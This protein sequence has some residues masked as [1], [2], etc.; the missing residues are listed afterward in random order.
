MKLEPI[1]KP[2]RIRIKLGNTEHSS[3][4][5]VKEDFS[6]KEL[7]PLFTDGRLERWLTQIGEIQLAKKTE[8]LSKQCGDD[9]LQNYILLSSVFFDEVANSLLMYENKDSF[10]IDDFLSSAPLEAIKVIYSKT[11][12]VEETD[13]A[14]HIDRILNL[15]NIYLIF[16]DTEL[17]KVYENKDE[18]GK[19]FASLIKNAD[20]YKNIFR[21]IENQTKA[22]PEFKDVLI[23]FYNASLNR[24]YEWG[25]IYEK[26]Y[27]QTLLIWYSNSIFRDNCKQ[28]WQSIIRPQLTIETIKKLFESEVYSDIYK[29]I[30]GEEFANIVKDDTD[31][32]EIFT[33]LEKYSRYQSDYE[34]SRNILS[35]FFN[36]MHNKG[37]VWGNIFK[38]DLS[39]EY[40]TYLYQNECVQILNIDWG[41][42]FAD[43]V[44]DWNT[45]SALIEDVIRKNGR[46]MISFYNS[47]VDKGFEEAKLKLNPWYVLANSDDFPEINRALNEWDGIRA[48]YNKADYNYSNIL[49]PL[50]KQILDFLQALIDLRGKN[51]SWREEHYY[52]SEYYLESEKEVMIL[53][54]NRYIS[55]GW[56]RFNKNA[57]MRLVEMRKNGVALAGY[58]L[59]NTQGYKAEKSYLGIAEYAVKLIAKKLRRQRV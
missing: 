2:V 40:L 20:D 57:E 21:Y 29:G 25:K 55:S 23:D 12:D 15:D 31:Y 30:W 58:A 19:K 22:F 8:E 45:D 9:N 32:K 17:H 52:D 3:V 46:D 41:K 37:Y 14:S 26:E 59:D 51:G 53:V 27:I 38:K 28:N 54:S 24:G 7:Y 36:V 13:W 16:E 44:S 10:S 1:A 47:C 50:G 34:R 11:K 6:I 5:S 49:L 4:D 48:H 39:I 35:T 56:M 43:C 33:Y 18:W 42:L